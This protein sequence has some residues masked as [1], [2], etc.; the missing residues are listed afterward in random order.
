MCEYEHELC[1]RL[2]GKV[3]EERGDNTVEYVICIHE[4]HKSKSRD[5]KMFLEKERFMIKGG[6]QTNIR[7]A[8]NGR[9]IVPENMIAREVKIHILVPIY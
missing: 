7:M 9:S 6:K 3:R 1:G 4:I 2:P 5:I 8:W